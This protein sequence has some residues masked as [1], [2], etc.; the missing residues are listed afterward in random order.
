M[1]IYVE[2]VFSE[3]LGKFSGY[4]YQITII[5]SN[6]KRDDFLNITKIDIVDALSVDVKLLLEL[7]RNKRMSV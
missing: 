2:T 5:Y 6:I 4:L 7:S 3:R 1:S